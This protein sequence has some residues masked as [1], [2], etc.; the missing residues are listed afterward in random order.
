[1][2]SSDRRA[3]GAHRALGLTPQRQVHEARVVE[4]REVVGHGQRF[5]ACHDHRVFQRKRPRRHQRGPG[6]ADARVE[7]RLGLGRTAVEANECTDGLLA[8]AQ[9]EADGGHGAAARGCCQPRVVSQ[10]G[11]AEVFAAVHHPPRDGLRRRGQAFGQPRCART[12]SWPLTSVVTTAQIETGHQV[13]AHETR[14]SATRRGSSVACVDWTMCASAER[15]T[16]RGRRARWASR[17]RVARS[18]TA[19]GSAAARWRGPG[20]ARRAGARPV[21]GRVMV[22]LLPARAR[23]T[24]PLSASHRRK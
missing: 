7:R 6:L 2:K 14:N 4:P 15:V 11:A 3:P 13:G 12:A 24:R 20:R 23:W 8:A 1:M 19:T 5:R 16:R 10:I 9:D 21:A 22:S 17:R 18:P